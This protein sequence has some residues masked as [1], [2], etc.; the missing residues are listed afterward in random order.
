VIVAGP[1]DAQWVEGAQN[2]GSVR[3]SVIVPW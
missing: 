2:A 3:I 1:L